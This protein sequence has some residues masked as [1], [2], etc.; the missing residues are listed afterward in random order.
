[1]TP[2]RVA[3]RGFAV[4][5]EHGAAL[6]FHAEAVFGTRRC[7]PAA[8]LEELHDRRDGHDRHRVARVGGERATEAL[9]SFAPGQNA[10]GLHANNVKP[11]SG[12]YDDRARSFYCDA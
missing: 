1:M 11:I 5:K 9:A 6:Q 7:V 2:W 12:L 4:T 8:P 10:C 3:L